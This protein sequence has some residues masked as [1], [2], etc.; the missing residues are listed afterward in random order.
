[1]CADVT[2]DDG[3]ALPPAPIIR[4]RLLVALSLCAVFAAMLWTSYWLV[5][6]W[7]DDPDR[8]V[9]PAEELRAVADDLRRATAAQRLTRRYL[10][11]RH[12]DLPERR[13][14]RETL[15]EVRDALLA[16]GYAVELQ[17]L[18]GTGGSC[19]RLDLASLGWTLQDDWPVLARTYPGLVVVPYPDEPSLA[20][21]RQQIEKLGGT[22][23]LLLRAD[24]FV[25]YL[26]TPPVQAKHADRKIFWP[27]HLHV[28]AEEYRRRPRTLADWAGDLGLA[29]AQTLH[30]LLKAR[31]ELVSRFG[32]E[33]LTTGGSISRDQLEASFA[34]A[35][36]PARQLAET[37][38]Q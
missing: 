38:G 36:P 35:T 21:L 16:A 10:S 33:A 9:T 19:H 1:V 30:D 17:P 6:R 32:L 26:L 22:G 12:L 25:C 8:P 31:P 4:R 20:E 24:W 2:A 15:A 37:L 18:P 34:G 5:L 13:V 11:L 14:W 28:L 7:A 27:I 23:P 29:H 3:T